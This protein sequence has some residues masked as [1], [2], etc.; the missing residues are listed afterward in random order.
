MRSPPHKKAI[1]LEADRFSLII[2]SSLFVVF[3]PEEDRSDIGLI[4]SVLSRFEAP[5]YLIQQFRTLPMKHAFAP[6][7]PVMFELLP[8][9]LVLTMR[10]HN[11]D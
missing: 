7:I 1:S 8:C 5:F 4:L 2:L 9:A 10:L 6:D 11:S 3:N